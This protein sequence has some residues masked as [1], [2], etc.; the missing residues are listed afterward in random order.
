M[1]KLVELMC[2]NWSWVLSKSGPE[3]RQ[4]SVMG[5]GSYVKSHFLPNM[6]LLS[7]ACAAAPFDVATK[8]MVPIW[9]QLMRNAYPP[10]GSIFAQNAQ[11]KKKRKIHQHDNRTKN[12]KK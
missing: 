12:D 5:F 2:Q 11:P 6:S 1:P 4:G 8:N 3:G 9:R 7:A 10:N